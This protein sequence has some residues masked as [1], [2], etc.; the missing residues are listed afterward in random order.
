[1][2]KKSKGLI[3]KKIRNLCFAIFNNEIN[4]AQFQNGIKEIISEYNGMSVIYQ[5][6]G[7]SIQKESLEYGDAFNQ[8]I[9]ELI[10][11]TDNRIGTSYNK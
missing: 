10:N 1:M 8:R 6:E 4:N 9:W 7:L 5:D 3:S 2:G 11:Q